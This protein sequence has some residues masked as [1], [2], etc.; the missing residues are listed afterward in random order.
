MKNTSVKTAFVSTN[1]IVQGE[2]PS[3]L[4]KP[5]MEQGIFINFGV[6]SFIWNNEAKGKAAVY[7]VII[8]F[9]YHKTEPNI[10]PYLLKAPNVFIEKR[11]KPLS[12]VP[13]MKKG[14]EMY[15]D[16]NLII[17]ASEYDEFITKEPLAEKYIRHYVGSEEFINKKTRYCL[18]LLDVSPNDLR[19]MPLVMQRVEAVKEFRLAS[20][21]E[22]TRKT[23]DTPTRFSVIHQPE[24][25]YILM[26]VVSSEKREYVPIGFMSPDVIVSYAVFTIP[27]ATLYHF[28][29][30]TSSVHMAWMRAVCGRLKGDYRYSN[31]IVYNNFP[32]PDTNE[33]G[34]AEI[35]KLAQNVLDARANHPTSTLAD[36]Y[37]PLT[38][39][40]DLLKAHKALDNAVMKLYNF[41]KTQT[42]PETV[43]ALMQLYQQLTK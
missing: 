25:D 37:D 6:P 22:A 27:N 14:N 39:P 21:R 3:T 33:A 8:G 7:C 15:D 41:P 19:K 9:S 43:A 40:P 30:L 10:N 17:E 31:T 4:W 29:I 13:K 11:S 36:L 26:P 32:W 35:T 38:M 2:H 24:S 18:W 5:L 20:K 12:N 16:A 1:S 34:Q 23:A 28:G 42:E